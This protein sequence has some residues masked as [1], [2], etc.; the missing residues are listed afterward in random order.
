M[1]QFLTP[2]WAKNLWL[3]A[4]LGGQVDFSWSMACRC[5][6]RIVPRISLSDMHGNLG[7]SSF[8]MTSNCSLHATWIGIQRTTIHIATLSKV[9]RYFFKMCFRIWGSL[10]CIVKGY[11]LCHVKW[12]GCAARVVLVIYCG[13][14]RH[15]LFTVLLNN[16]IP[17][18]C[19]ILSLPTFE[20]SYCK[21]KPEKTRISLSHL[22]YSPEGPVC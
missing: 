13:M 7:S 18:L 2:L 9:S 11:F 5:F 16:A 3:F 14:L 20:G 10:L 21:V 1:L 4:T 17:D 19:T 6:W 22:W 15:A 12:V 8:K